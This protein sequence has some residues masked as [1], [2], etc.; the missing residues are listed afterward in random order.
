M[1]M[2]KEKTLARLRRL[3]P[4]C[5][6]LWLLLFLYILFRTLVGELCYVPSGSMENTVHP[7]WQW[8][9]RTT[10]GCRLPRC[11]SEIPVVK[12]AVMSS[13]TAMAVDSL[14]AW[15]Y[16]RL[17]G[18]RKPER[19]D[20]IVF[21]SPENPSLLLVK[22]V[23][24]LP[25]DTLQIIDGRVM[26]NG[27]ELRMPQ[28]VIPT[29]ARDTCAVT[30]Y[31]SSCFGWNKHNYGPVVVPADERSYFVLGDNRANS[32]DSRFWGLVGWHDIVGRMIVINK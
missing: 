26:V 32:N 9:D 2:D 18:W 12:M 1:R 31:P 5:R 20:I 15:G 28:G 6:T 16:C 7:G 22:R 3:V 14:M 30:T 27:K 21:N 17:P 8:I 29:T 23:V 25:G 10:Y 24:A 19:L 4:S 13:E 11:L